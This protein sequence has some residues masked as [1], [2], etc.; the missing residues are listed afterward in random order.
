VKVGV[1]NGRFTEVTG[2]ELEDGMSVITEAL[3]ASS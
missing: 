2:G 1:T 3:G